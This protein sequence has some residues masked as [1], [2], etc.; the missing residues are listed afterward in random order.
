MLATEQTTEIQNGR[1]CFARTVA[2]LVVLMTTGCCQM[3]LR[4]PMRNECGSPILDCVD[5]AQCEPA[6]RAAFNGLQEFRA[7]LQMHRLQA[8]AKMS[9]SLHICSAKMSDRWNESCIAQWKAERREKLTA[10]P[11][12]KFHPLPTHPAF[13]PESA[14]PE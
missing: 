9:D 12:P 5:P 2:L 1:A 7:N 13:Y 4:G 11:C 10:P 14:L 6:E 3:V 8:S